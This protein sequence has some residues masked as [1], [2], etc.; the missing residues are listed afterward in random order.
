MIAM[1]DVAAAIAAIIGGRDVV[2]P[3]DIACPKCGEDRPTLITEV[4]DPM[5]R[6]FFC[7]VCAHEFR[8][9]KAWDGDPK[10][11]SH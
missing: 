10:K 8:E 9:T 3:G 7:A 11:P 5:G 4:V 6:R 2:Q 1:V